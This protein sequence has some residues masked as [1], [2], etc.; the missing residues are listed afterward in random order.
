MYEIDNLYIKMHKD[1]NINYNKDKSLLKVYENEFNSI[2]KILEI[3]LNDLKKNLND[4]LNESL[5]FD[6]ID[7]NYSNINNKENYDLFEYNLIKDKV[8]IDDKVKI[9]IVNFKKELFIKELKKLIDAIKKNNTLTLIG[10]IEESEKIQN[11]NYN[12]MPCYINPDM[13]YVLN[14]YAN[15]N[16]NYG[17]YD[18][19]INQH[20]ISAMENKYKKYFTQKE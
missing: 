7:I 9:K 2:N 10:S 8:K 3:H 12:N 18:T 20:K 16:D 6:E 4:L 1:K 11:F 5:I 15:I 13:A 19:L 14:D 17:D